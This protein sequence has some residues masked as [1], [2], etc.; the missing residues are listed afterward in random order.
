LGGGFVRFG[1]N[2]RERPSITEEKPRK[3]PA[4]R[5]VIVERKRPK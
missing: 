4:E 5:K 3:A 2:P 1:L